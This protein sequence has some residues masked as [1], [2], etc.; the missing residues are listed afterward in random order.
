MSKLTVPIK[1]MHCRSCE[2]LLEGEMSKISGVKK[3]GVNHKTGL[4]EIFYEGDKPEENRFKEVIENAGYTLG[5]KEK[6]TWVSHNINDYKILLSAGVILLVLYFLAKILG[7]LNLDVQAE[8]TSLLFVLLIGLV[9]GVS[10]CMALVGGLVLGISARHA[11]LHPEATGKQKFLP[12]LFFNLGRIVGFAFLGGLIGLVGSSFKMSAS[13]LGF[14]T[15]IIGLVMLFLGL[16][17]IEIFPILR[18]KSITLPKSISNFFGINKERAEYSHFGSLVAGMMTFFLPCGF[19]QAMQIY[20]VSTGSFVGGALVMF[21]FALGTSVGLISVGGL[22]SFF[23]GRKA[24]IFFVTAGLAVIIFGSYNILNGSRLFSFNKQVDNS[25]V[26][27]TNEVQ[28]IRMEQGSRGYT[29]NQF[30][31]KKG[32]KVRWI[33]TSTNPYTCASSLMV[34]KLGISRYLQQGDNIIEFTPTQTGEISFSCSMG[35]YR[36]KF[37]VQ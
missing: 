25:D 36:G 12:H 7:I 10:T 13:V 23:K 30:T 21:L 6:L 4:A 14:L 27:T 24:K 31:I 22:S 1:G 29:P 32:V 15:I 37:I 16:K 5:N 20:A 26:V 17:L 34:P 18:D 28:E 3:V 33:V 35:M 2:I 8:N 19:T 9:A 11:K